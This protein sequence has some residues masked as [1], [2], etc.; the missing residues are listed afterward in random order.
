MREVEGAASMTPRGVE[1]GREEEVGR[2]EMRIGE[3]WVEGEE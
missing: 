2:G 3:E 1:E